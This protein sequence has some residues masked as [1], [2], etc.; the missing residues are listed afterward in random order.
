MMLIVLQLGSNSILLTFCFCIHLGAV[1]LQHKTKQL[2]IIGRIK[3]FIQ[4]IIQQRKISLLANRLVKNILEQPVNTPSLWL[5][6]K[7]LKNLH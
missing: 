2:V 3:C 5:V 4:R 6:T 1:H 7:Q